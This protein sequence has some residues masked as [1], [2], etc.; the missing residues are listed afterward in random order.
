MAD[1][2]E[3][4]EPRFGGLLRGLA[5]AAEA[6][7]LRP[8]LV[9]LI[10]KR[11]WRRGWPDL[12]PS[13]D[14]CLAHAASGPDHGV[15]VQPGTLG[16]A[17]LDVDGGDLGPEGVAEVAREACGDGAVLCVTPSSSGALG[18]RASWGYVCSSRVDT[19]RCSPLSLSV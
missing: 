1:G 3:G 10:H 14:R 2:H 4:R 16:C 15:G 7:G 13:V 9:E 17:V 12:R 8:G 6:R 11:G 5:D 18:S 19:E